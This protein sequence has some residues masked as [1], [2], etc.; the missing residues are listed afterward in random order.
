METTQTATE[1]KPALEVIIDGIKIIEDMADQ[2]M[3]LEEHWTTNNLDRRQQ[4]DY[5]TQFYKVMKT[6]IETAKKTSPYYSTV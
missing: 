6:V 2:W 4:L 1:K 5:A 3:M